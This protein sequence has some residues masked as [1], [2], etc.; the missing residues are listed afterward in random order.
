MGG[1]AY[2][3]LK[4]EFDTTLPKPD[5]DEVRKQIYALTDCIEEE[6]ILSCHDI[7]D[8]GLGVALSEMAF[9]NNIGF[10]I[11]IDENLRFDEILFSETG[12]FIMEVDSN[13]LEAV[14][15]TFSNYNIELFTIGKTGG[16]S[17]MI[18]DFLNITLQEAKNAWEN[19]LNSKL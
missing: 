6:L 7:S 2:Y 19:G 9:E 13:K 12:G 3:Q 11:R 15:K 14:F 10:K 18:N 17:L 8:G 4:N 1:S 5:L 16:D